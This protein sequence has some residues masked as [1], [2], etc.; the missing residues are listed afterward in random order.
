MNS[1]LYATFASLVQAR[2]NCIAS[3]NDEWRE[4]HGERIADLLDEMPSGSGIDCGTKIDLDASTGEKLVF[5]VAYLHMNDGGFYDGWTQHTVI[6]TPS[7]QFGF[8]LRITGRDRN[9][10][11]EY[12]RDV[13]ADALDQETPALEGTN[14]ASAQ[15]GLR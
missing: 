6:V 5:D 1:K 10:I 15:G 11:K 3:H 9:G 13:Y 4:K 8:T 2:L 14:S 12:L 7:L